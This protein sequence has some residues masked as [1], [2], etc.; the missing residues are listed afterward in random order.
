MGEMIGSIAHQ[1]RQ[2]LNNISLILHFI[3][4]NYKKMDET[5]I[6]KYTSNAKEQL[7]YMSTT[8][9]DFRNFYKPSKKRVLFDVATAIEA[10]ISILK[11]QIQKNEISLELSDQTFK[12]FGFENEFKQAIL[13]IL[14][15][16]IEAIKQ[17][18]VKNGTIKIEI[19]KSSI[20]IRNNGGIASKEV[21][22][23]MFE[24]YFTTKFEDKGT[25]IGLYMTKTIIENMQGHIK[26][27][28]TQDGVAFL[29]EF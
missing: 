10:S 20:E 5:Q 19:N 21:L 24:P 6:Q 18:D 4:D 11:S 9:D 7:E 23:R 29:I 28:N 3:K 22:E 27:F 14:S 1:W 15:N 25:G 16:A 2:P 8:I 12:I 17:N 26:S 13:N